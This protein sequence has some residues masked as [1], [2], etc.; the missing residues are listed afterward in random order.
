MYGGYRLYIFGMLW[1]AFWSLTASFSQNALMLDF[2]RALQ[3]IGPAAFLSSGMMLL[4]C[5]YRPGPRKNFVL[6]VYGACAPLGFFIGIFFAGI[7][8]QYAPWATYFWVGGGLALITAVTTYLTVPSDAAERREMNVKM[9]YW[10]AG[11]TVAGLVFFTFAVIDSS[12]APM[13]WGTSYIILSLMMGIGLLIAAGYFEVYIALHPLLPLSFFQ[14]PCMK[15]FV[16]ALFFTYG[17]LG[18]FLLYA[19]FYMEV[20]M[21]ATP[22]Q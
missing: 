21:K 5:T 22:F 6:S 8:G 16:V 19:T 17:S 4:G 13:G 2:C 12:H 18:I 3:G 1:L 11:I 10:G 20:V 15:P 9:D 7:A 14:A